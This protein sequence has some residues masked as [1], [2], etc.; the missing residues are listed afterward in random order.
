MGGS[1]GRNVQ[2]EGKTLYRVAEV[3]GPTP[4][5]KGKK[6]LDPQLNLGSPLFPKSQGVF[7]VPEH[8]PWCGNQQR[9]Q[10]SL[11]FGKFMPM[12][13]TWHFGHLGAMLPD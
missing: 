9:R 8:R 4:Q 10:P 5:M 1:R 3:Q 11:Y 12:S 2:R 13:L 7:N 6:N